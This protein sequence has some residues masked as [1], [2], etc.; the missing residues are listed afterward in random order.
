MLL[1]NESIELLLMILIALTPPFGM[2]SCP[3]TVFPPGLGDLGISPLY[4]HPPTP[5]LSKGQAQVSVNSN[6]WKP[7]TD[8]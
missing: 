4:F 3:A 6:Q 2:Y 8:H 5:A 1:T 7:N